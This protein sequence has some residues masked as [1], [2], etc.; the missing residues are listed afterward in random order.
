MSTAPLT[1]T[2]GAIDVTS[3]VSSL[4]SNE[5][6]ELTPLTT[7]AA[8]YNAELSAYSSVSSALSTFQTALSQLNSAAF[9][10]QSAT[11]ANSGIA[12]ATTGVGVTS[13]AFTTTINSTADI[14]PQSQIIQSAG[15]NAATIFNA[16]DSIALQVGTNTPT[17]VTLSSN[18]TLPGLVDAINN[19]QTNVS[20][21][22]VTDGNGS[23]L[24]LQATS[25]GT[26]NTIKVSS[27]GSLSAFAYNP[28]AGAPSTMTQTQ[29]PQ[30]Q[31]AAIS[32]SYNIAVTSLAASDKIESAAITDG[33]TYNSSSGILAIKT[34]TGATALIQ[35]TSNTLSGIRDAINAS[36]A[37]VNATIVD[38][39][40]SS[41]LVLTSENSGAANTITVTGTG[42]F[43]SLST[44]SWTDSSGT[45]EAS[46]MT[47]EQAAQDATVIVDGV[48]ITSSS[49][50][51]T[52]AVN[53]VT[54]NLNSVTTA[55]DNYSLTIANNPS[56]VQTTA[57]A[58]VSA[59][60]ALI[61]VLN[62]L[63]SYDSTTSTG[64]A[65]QGDSTLTSIQNQ[66]RNAL[67][68]PV[69]DGGALQTLN[70]VGISLQTDGTLALDSTTLTTATTNS[71]NDI[72]ALFNSPTDGIVTSL[73]TLL[74]SMLDPTTGIVAN[75]TTGIQS[76]LTSNA[77]SQTA[78]E[79]QMT[80]DQAM[81]TAE[82]TALNVT[83]TT[84][85]STQAA[86]T[87]ELAGLVTTS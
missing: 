64:G 2:V 78:M 60:N 10:A 33:T 57:Q 66:I 75:R 62:P 41:H 70:D 63:N 74:T 11:I 19:A 32:G 80:A 38:D 82:F 21:S 40:T 4:M 48:P 3:L 30:D 58:F 43:A 1:S 27:N 37:G 69:T 16:G 79:T 26:A 35:P 44:G 9:S 18:T 51:I 8:S 76:S 52:N 24:V 25:S 65:L 81:Y 6:Q 5:A 71:F 53:G 49:N 50:T 7:A 15:M 46:T 36:D 56:G 39:G 67:I 28:S 61:G 59:Y 83:L 23:H 45:T 85:Q 42:D 31:L 87:T 54:L 72:S 68:Q 86:L 84:M 55:S 14:S 77:A 34:G 29:A 47:T 22:I 17:F 20:A 73:N 13:S 12:N